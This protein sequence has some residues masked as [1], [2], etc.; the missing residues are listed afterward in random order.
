[1]TVFLLAS[2]ATGGTIVKTISLDQAIQEASQYIENRLEQGVIIAL[3]NFSSASERFSDY[4]LEG[5]SEHLVKGG[6]LVVVDRKDLDLIRKEEQFQLSGEVSDESAQ[7]IGKKLGAQ[8]IISGI[9][10][11]LGRSYLFRIKTLV[12]ET[13]AIAAT[14]SS[15]ISVR[16]ER[17]IHLLEGAKTV[18]LQ[19]DLLLEGLLYEVI[20]GQYI[21]I[22]KYIGSE[23]NVHI[24]ASIN[25]LPVTAIGNNA[26]SEHKSLKSITIPSS[27]ITIGNSAFRL[28]E[29]LTSVIIPSSI[30]TIEDSAFQASG[31][32]SVAI[33]SSVKTIGK[34]AFNL[35]DKLKSINV[36][37]GN[38]AYTSVNGV[39]F[40]KSGQTLIC[41]PAGKGGAYTI[42]SSVTTIGDEAFFWCERL[43]NVTIP[44]SVTTI[45]GSAFF[46]CKR[47]TNV[48]IPS[49]VTMIGNGAFWMCSSLTSVTIPPSVTMIGERA[50]LGTR[51]T[52]VT[53]SRKT[54]VGNNT[55]PSGVRIQYRN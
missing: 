12:V 7:A 16:E 38:G 17:V 52:I 33:P 11:D 23:E 47:L 6:K 55:F 5:L 10:N 40:D 2:C 27:V 31:L 25:G 8:V 39:L 49:S 20:S 30:I 46:W 53:L 28:C 15:E 37:P 34:N 48:T 43:T 29:R 19:E 54:K 35:C 18:R 50:F 22:T 21:T 9:L 45:G 42:P 51:L 41:Y 3:L 32:A 14:A 13:A 36:D 4:V 24:T 1:L 26:F 44:S